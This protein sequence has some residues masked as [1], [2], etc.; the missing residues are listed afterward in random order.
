MITKCVTK[1]DSHCAQEKLTYWGEYSNPLLDRLPKL[2]WGLGKR[3]PPDQREMD[4][5]PETCSPWET[6]HETPSFPQIL[7]SP[8]YILLILQ[9]QAQVSPSQK[10]PT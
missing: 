6:S 5:R 8:I 9:G 4:S 7:V 2:S 10:L 1:G 3:R